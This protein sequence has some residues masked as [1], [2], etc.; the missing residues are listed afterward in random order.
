MS[1]KKFVYLLMMAAIVCGFIASDTTYGQSKTANLLFKGTVQNADGTP[2]PG[3]SVAGDITGA[4]ALPL[5]PV[6]SGPDGSYQYSF[7]SL[8]NDITAGDVVQFTVTDS[9]Q[10]CCR[11]SDIYCKGCGFTRSFHSGP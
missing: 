11:G 1:S 8:S 3:H 9:A 5:S 4:S 10:E 2:A 6:R 7:I